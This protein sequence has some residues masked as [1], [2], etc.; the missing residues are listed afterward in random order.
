[1]FKLENRQ[2]TAGVAAGDQA[3]VDAA[4][5]IMDQGGNAVDAAIAGIFASFMSEPVLTSL[6]GGGIMTLI[7]P[8]GEA[9]GLEFFSRMPGKG[10]EKRPGKF[11]FYDVSVDFGPTT[12][13]FHVGKASAAIPGT[14]MGIFEAHR[15]WGRLSMEALVEPAVE[16]AREG[17]FLTS[18]MVGI[19]H[20]LDPILRRSDGVYQ[21]FAPNGVLLEAGELFKNSALADLLTALAREGIWGEA[22]TALHESQLACFGPPYGLFTESDMRS[23]VP[24]HFKPMELLFLGHQIFLPPPPALGGVL[25]GQGLKRIASE[26]QDNLTFDSS[27]VM[28]SRIL[29]SMSAGRDTVPDILLDPAM[30]SEAEAWAKG[31]ISG[32][33][34]TG[35][36][37]HISVI[38]KDGMAVSVTHSNGEGCGHLVE[39]SGMMMNN[40]LGEED[41][42]PRGFH[43]QKPGENLVTMMCP[44]VIKSE[45][46]IWALGSG[47]SNRI[48]SAVCQVIMNLFV[49]GMSPEEAV[50]APRLHVEKG[51]VNFE[52]PG[53]SD[54]LPGQLH[55]NY[56]TVIPFPERNM[57]F[58]GVHIVG[59]QEAESVG[60]GDSRRGGCCKLF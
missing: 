14:L 3:T 21:L 51:V 35:S 28:V 42:N 50:M 17:V 39:G 48:R 57:F 54:E 34:P 1:M 56:Q 58:G 30:M 41:I 7:S 43:Q 55:D 59:R 44:T 10:L 33:S 38:D 4:I 15:R 52:I 25:V 8:D 5:V 37:T 26:L 9:E 32:P 24:R 40:F 53:M 36:T 47:G 19:I 27:R 29:G 45:G 22:M 60:M 31:A 12:Q 23:Y 6:F 16:L 20:L 13:T 11:D 18:Q 49:L 46:D 2:I